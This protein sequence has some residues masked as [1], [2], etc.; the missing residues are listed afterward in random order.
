M[1]EHIKKYKYWYIGLAIALVI[2]I[3][4]LIIKAKSKKATAT[5]TAPLANIDGNTKK[6]IQS[7]LVEPTVKTIPKMDIVH[8][9]TDEAE[10]VPVFPLKKGKS[11]DEVVNVKLMLNNVYGEKLTLTPEFDQA[12]EDAL[13]L[14]KDRNNVSESYYQ[15]LGFAK[16]NKAV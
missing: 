4:W 2:L 9:K 10:N 6:E 5:A 8:T 15:K 16:W 7:D 14:H 3:T 1:I 12:T 11:S 13:L